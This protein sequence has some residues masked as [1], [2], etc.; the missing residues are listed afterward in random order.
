METPRPNPENL[1]TL[2]S[3][4]PKSFRPRLLSRL[5]N[6]FLAGILVTAPIGITIYLT[7]SLITWVD[8]RVLPLLPEQYN[9]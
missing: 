3:A 6:N 9:P 4:G 8:N 2:P 7:W 1:P 5:R